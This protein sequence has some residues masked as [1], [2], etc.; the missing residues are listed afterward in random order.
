MDAKLKSNYN[1][2][3]DNTL[4]NDDDAYLSIDS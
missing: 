3:K 2:F 4:T 1:K